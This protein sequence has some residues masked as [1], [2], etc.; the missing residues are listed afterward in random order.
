[1]KNTISRRQ[2]NKA[3]G[4]AVFSAAAPFVANRRARASDTADVIVIGAGLAGLNAA[5]ILSEAGLS[6][7]VLEGSGRI[8]GRAWTAKETWRTEAGE[9]PIE[10]GASQV[11]PSYARVLDT[12]NRLE[13]P[14]VAQ[15]RKALPFAYHLGGRLIRRDDWADSPVNRTVGDERE[16]LPEQFAGT[17]TA[18]LN[19]LKEPGDW[20]DPRFSDYDVSWYELYKRN[21]VSEAGIRLAGLSNAGDLFGHSALRFFHDAT[22]FAVSSSFVDSETAKQWPRN[23][24][25]G[26]E[27]L[28]R[29]MAAQ[30]PSEVRLGQQVMAIDAGDDSVELRTLDGGRYRAKFVIS[31]LPF[32]VLRQVAIWPRPPEPQYQAITG[33]NYAETTRAFVRISEPFWE[34]DGFEPSL[35]TDGA[36]RQ[37][38]V[39]K[40]QS[41]EGEHRGVFVVSGSM[42]RQVAARPPVE[43]AR[44]LVDELARI[45]PASRGKVTVIRYH[46]WERQP[47][48]RGCSPVFAPGQITAFGRQMILPHGRLHFAGEHTRRLDVGMESA[49]ESGE[50]TALEVLARA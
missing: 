11:G 41:G 23:I 39:I 19:P 29:T 30:L 12:I 5:W 49:M 1:M 46:S 36:V 40:N 34:D 50:R 32:S 4:A 42:G 3:L 18:R 28:P 45:R 47:L 35:M 9:V 8:G 10:L 21:G 48:Q 37:F 43:A 14:T 2:V 15:D 16:I 25:G 20:L 22:R 44:F 38:W 31:T 17:L 26:T 27:V 24:V 13:I 7:L 33:L 6:T